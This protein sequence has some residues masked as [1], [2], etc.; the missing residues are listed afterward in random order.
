M[1]DTLTAGQNVQC[2]IEKVPAS[3][4]AK[5][6]ICRLMRR[7]PAIKKSL[8]RAQKLRRKRMHTYIRG[9]RVWYDREKSARVARWIQ[10]FCKTAS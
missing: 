2:T 6:T 5:D 8:R 4:A 10:P 7:D 9:N 3:K 1:I